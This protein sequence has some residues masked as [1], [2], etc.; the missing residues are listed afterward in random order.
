M[1]MAS[2]KYRATFRLLF[3]CLH[4]LTTV[5]LQRLAM[6]DNPWLRSGYRAL[7]H[8]SYL[9]CIASLCYPHN[10]LLNVYTHL[11]GSIYFISEGFF[12]FVRLGKLQAPIEDRVVFLTYALLVRR[13]CVVS[14]A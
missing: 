10:D 14:I 6:Y 7:G 11:V 12:S 5:D 8:N 3:S 1:E 9:Q 4:N 2:N 13:C